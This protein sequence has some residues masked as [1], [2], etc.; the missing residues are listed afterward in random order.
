[1]NTNLINANDVIESTPITSSTDVDVTKIDRATIKQL[2]K[3]VE[4][5]KSMKN[6][7]AMR[8]VS[9]FDIQAFFPTIRK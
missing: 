3:N 6:V 7:D 2:R 9:H 1:M 8:K 4:K 5:L